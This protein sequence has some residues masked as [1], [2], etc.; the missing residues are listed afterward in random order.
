MWNSDSAAIR[1]Q[2]KAPVKVG[3]LRALRVEGPHSSG[4]L[5]VS[6][7][8]HLARSRT[9]RRPQQPS[10][11]HDSRRLAGNCS[12][13]AQKTAVFAKYI[14]HKPG[15]QTSAEILNDTK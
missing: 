9:R 10:L 2:V 15:T 5:L 1:D 13:T 4:A 6:H 7:L 8:Q 12:S 11:N 3:A 14:T